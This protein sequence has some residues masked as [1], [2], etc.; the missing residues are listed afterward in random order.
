MMFRSNKP[1]QAKK[2]RAAGVET[3]FEA[4]RR[5]LAE[6]EKSLKAAAKR[7]EQFIVEAPKIAEKLQKEQ[8]ERF[9]RNAAHVDSRAS[10]GEFRLPDNRYLEADGAVLPRTRRRDRQQG[11]WLFF[12]L[13]AGLVAA[14]VWAWQMLV[15]PN[16]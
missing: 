15:A 11:K 9:I 12:L 10:R 4:R 16:F 13:V 8:R 2:T 1:A 6:Q 3:P 14:A 5:E 7:H